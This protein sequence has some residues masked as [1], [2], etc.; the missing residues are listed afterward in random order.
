M[1]EIVFAGAMSH[2]PGAT[3]WPEKADPEKRLNFHQAAEELGNR[4]KASKPDVIIG[5]SND[6]VLNYNLRN[7][8]NFAVGIGEEHSGPGE[9]FESWLKVPR[10]RLKGEPKISG[11]LYNGL[12]KKGI[13]IASHPE[14]FQ[15]DDNF[16]VPLTLTGLTEAG[17]P[18]IPIMMNCTVPPVLSSKEAYKAGQL[19]GEVIRKFVPDDIRVAILATGGLS[20]EPG[21][22]KYFVI[23][24]QFDR[25]V[26]NHLANSHH[27]TI[28]EEITYEKMEEA[29]SGGTAEL[30]AWFVVMAAVGEYK[31]EVLAY[32]AP[33]EWR[34]GMGVVQWDL[35]IPLSVTSQQGGDS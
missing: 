34:C 26:M 23:D 18:F 15:Y 10:Y 5:L 25:W 22:P 21:G 29:G 12:V 33:R 9:W 13:N 32:E 6:H 8:P 19:L 24:E 27:Q 4:I 20:H 35:G 1:A 30:L 14:N 3:G 7:F 16:S 31:C 17:I 28:I 2:A 11:Q